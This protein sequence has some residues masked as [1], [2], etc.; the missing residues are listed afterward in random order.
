MLNDTS[1]TPTVEL[2]DLT[3]AELA[4]NLAL[5]EALLDDAESSPHRGELL[6]LWES[7]RH[8]VVLGRSSQVALEVHEENCRQLG[9]P[10]VRR[11][12]G[13]AAVLVGP[14]FLM[15]SLVLDLQARPE[16]RSLTQ[17]H[18]AVLGRMAAA[19]GRLLPAVRC[20]G[21]SDLALDGR[22]FSGN[23]LRY[24]KNHLLY[25]GTILYAFDLQLVDRCLKMPPRQP[26]YRQG[27]GH[28]QFLT[29][30]PLHPAA[31]R[32]ALIEA[33]DV[34]SSRQHWPAELTARLVAERY[35]QPSWT[36]LR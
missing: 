19:L 23:S 30:V 17:A 2:L 18:G 10:V 26:D 5:D 24:R 32:Q 8:A 3:L 27:R 12:S 14:G 25:H 15:Y 22:K 31:I 9:V 29:N 28:T 11:I 20:Q 36:A 6:R 16:L 7:P 13:G 1:A 4:E 33:W 21:I 35:S 34:H